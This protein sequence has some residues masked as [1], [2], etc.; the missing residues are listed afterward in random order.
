MILTAAA[1]RLAAIDALLPSDGADPR[2][3][4]GHHVYDSRAAAIGDLD[5]AEL[6]ADR[7]TP[8]IA[9]YTLSADADLR[10]EAAAHDDAACVTVLEFV[11]ELAVI[12]QEDGEFLLDAKAGDD[13][14]AHLVL[15]ALMAQVRRVLLH[16]EKARPFRDLFLSHAGDKLE[17]MAVPE[18]GLNYHRAF[19]RMTFRIRD[20]GF[21][22]ASGLP[23]HVQAFAAGLPDGSHAKAKLLALGGHLAAETRTALAGI[24]H[25]PP[26]DPTRPQD[27]VPGFTATTNGG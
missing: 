1:L 24:D 22:D 5:D 27:A 11:G 17:F 2:T 19:L 4:A 16:S 18:L 12:T 8:I 10:G 21:P 15:S 7:Y 20:D 13:P 14:Q 6:V 9:V 25:R 3:L 26:D 23:P